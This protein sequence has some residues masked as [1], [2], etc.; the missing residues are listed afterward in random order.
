MPRMRASRATCLASPRTLRLQRGWRSSSRCLRFHI[1][2]TARPK[3]AEPAEIL[4]AGSESFPENS[5]SQD[6]LAVDAEIPIELK[7]LGRSGRV[8]KQ[9]S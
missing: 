6:Y 8:E 2:R 1:A 5:R 4:A 9:R 7:H 3:L